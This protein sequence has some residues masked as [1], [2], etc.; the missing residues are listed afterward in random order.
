MKRIKFS[1]LFIA[2]LLLFIFFNNLGAYQ[3]NPAEISNQIDLWYEEFQDLYRQAQ[4]TNAENKLNKIIKTL[5]SDPYLESWRRAYQKQPTKETVYAMFKVLGGQLQREQEVAFKGVEQHR[6]TEEI[7][8]REQ[9]GWEKI[10]LAQK[11]KEE[12][13]RQQ[14]EV[15]AKRELALKAREAELPWQRQEHLKQKVEPRDRK[16]W[17]RIATEQEYLRRKRELLAKKE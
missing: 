13:L 12:Q 17:E 10:A 3:K 11:Y 15:I 4:Y 16:E 8:Q 1:S 2:S 5:D 7:K 9:Q 6:Q 14:E